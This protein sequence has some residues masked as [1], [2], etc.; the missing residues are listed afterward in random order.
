MSGKCVHDRTTFATVEC[1]LL[2][3]DVV[4]VSADVKRRKR[5]GST[6]YDSPDAEKK[7]LNCT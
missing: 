5:L 3:S 7:E 6:V 4:S 1:F 2:H